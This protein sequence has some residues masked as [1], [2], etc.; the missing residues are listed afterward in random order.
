MIRNC[1]YYL[2]RR[3]CT[4]IWAAVC[5][6][7]YMTRSSK[8]LGHSWVN[9]SSPS[10][11]EVL[12]WLRRQF[13]REHLLF[14]LARREGLLLIQETPAEA[15]E[16]RIN[17]FGSLRGGV[18]ILFSEI[19]FEL[20]ELW[21]VYFVEV[22]SSWPDEKTCIQVGGYL[23]RV[24]SFGIRPGRH[25]H[26]PGTSSASCWGWVKS[27]HGILYLMRGSVGA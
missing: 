19:T 12:T 8:Y 2:G 18:G 10:A 6:K 14:F 3:C 20:T 22:C 25:A 11:P 21:N 24:W 9:M 5:R 15:L 27:K 16:K 26:E 1:S 23:H 17:L 4:R 7:I 13:K